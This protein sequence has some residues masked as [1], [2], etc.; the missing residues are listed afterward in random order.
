[1]LATIQTTKAGTLVTFTGIGLYDINKSSA[2]MLTT[3]PATTEQ[4]SQQPL[5]RSIKNKN[6]SK[7][8]IPP[9]LADV[10]KYFASKSESS[11]MA[12]EFFDHFDSNGWLVGGKAPMRKWTAAASNWIRRQENFNGASKGPH[13]QGNRATARD[14]LTDTTWASP[15][16]QSTV[17]DPVSDVSVVSAS[18]PETR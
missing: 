12:N 17:R 14:L 4:P 7:E 10:E 1:M 15:V 8:S 6:K 13:R 2:T 9:P 11:E 18:G 3:D 16:D 5:T